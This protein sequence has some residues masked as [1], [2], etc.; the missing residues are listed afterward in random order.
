MKGETENV[1]KSEWEKVKKE[2]LR[3]RL[4]WSKSV[5]VRETERE[6]GS[7]SAEE[8]REGREGGMAAHQS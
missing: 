5:G 1:R 8:E 3:K 2:T 6:R 4:S 7:K